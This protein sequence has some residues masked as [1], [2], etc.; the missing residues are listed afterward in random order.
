MGVIHGDD[1]LLSTLVVD[2]HHHVEGSFPVDQ[3]QQLL[4]QARFERGLFSDS[5]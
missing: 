4:Q 3:Q 1:P 2:D 5:C